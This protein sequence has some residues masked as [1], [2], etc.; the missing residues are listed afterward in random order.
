[1]IHDR[2]AF[3]VSSYYN[4][5]KFIDFFFILYFSCTKTTTISNRTHALDVIFIFYF[6]IG[7]FV[8]FGLYNER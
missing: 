3:D 1:M 4:I 2:L 6:F 5:G 8:E 7:R